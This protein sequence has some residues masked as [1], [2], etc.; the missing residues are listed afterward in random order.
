MARTF[1]AA[2]KGVADKRRRFD[3]GAAATRA[4]ADGLGVEPRDTLNPLIE[5]LAKSGT[6]SAFEADRLKGVAKTR[7]DAAHREQFT[8][9]SKEV[10]AALDDVRSVLSRALG[11]GR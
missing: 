10:A 8:Y 7:N 11:R 4:C 1:R 3:P 5:K 6:L 2:P 9:G